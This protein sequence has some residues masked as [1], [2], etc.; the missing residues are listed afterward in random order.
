MA[1]ATEKV[2]FEIRP[3]FTRSNIKMKHTLMHYYKKVL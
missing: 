1:T 2:H 3:T